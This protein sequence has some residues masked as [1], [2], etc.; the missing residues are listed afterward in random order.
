MQAHLDHGEWRQDGRCTVCTCGQRLYAGDAPSTA[1]GRE[2]VAR[3]HARLKKSLRAEW[4]LGKYDRCE[5]E[6]A[7][8]REEVSRFAKE[9]GRQGKR[10]ASATRG[11]RAIY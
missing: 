8:A 11:K 3:Y 7:R 6:R 4:E 10:Q 1:E 5:K 9:Q 2:A